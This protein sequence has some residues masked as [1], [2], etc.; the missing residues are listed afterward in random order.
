MF[1]SILYLYTAKLKSEQAH[2][3]DTFFEEFFAGQAPKSHSRKV[4]LPG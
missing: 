3:A 2:T 1:C 4:W